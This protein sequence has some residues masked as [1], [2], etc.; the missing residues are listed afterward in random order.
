MSLK[1]SSINIPGIQIPSP[2]VT[3]SWQFFTFLYYGITPT[4]D[5]FNFWRGDV[6]GDI[7]IIY[8][9]KE[10]SPTWDGEVVVSSTWEG[11]RDIDQD[12]ENE[13][14]ESNTWEELGDS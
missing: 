12:F 14:S 7:N 13:N 9:S 3:T 11:D 2:D 4:T 1:V 5:L 10:T 8:E 6:D